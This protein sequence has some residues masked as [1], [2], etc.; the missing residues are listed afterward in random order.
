[1]FK[2]L[3]Y[4]FL[5]HRQSRAIGTAFFSIGFLFGTWATFIPFVKEKFLLNDA[6][7]GLL[8][9]SMPMGAL[10]MNIVGAWLVA[11][12]G[13]KTTTILGMT[14]MALAFLIP[15]NATSIYLLPVGLY[16][17]GS[18]ISITNIAM[19]MGVTNIEA[20]FKINIMSTCHG[21]FSIGLMIGS[22]M[23]SSARGFEVN[24][25]IT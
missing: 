25:G 14:G 7:L 13:M 22:L 21:M 3:T 9:L 1:L 8:L 24:P 4:D 2:H 16:L 17:C 12:V 20:H 11:K 19:N 10:T 15:I 5:S 23:A 6:D 18:F